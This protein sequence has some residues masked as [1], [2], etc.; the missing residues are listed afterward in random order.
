VRAVVTDLAVLE[1]GDDGELVLT[2]VLDDS[3]GDRTSLVRE[4]VQRCGWDLPVAREVAL[5]DAVSDSE[6]AA[7][8]T[9]DPQGH[10]VA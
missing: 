1:R 2:G 4:A 9:Y 6:L 5:L 10:F 8:R 7:V 3:A